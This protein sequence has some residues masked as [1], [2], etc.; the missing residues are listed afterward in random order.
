MK[1]KGQ[2]EKADG[3]TAVTTD[4]I[5]AAE[6]ASS[7]TNIFKRAKGKAQYDQN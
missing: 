3:H 1:G 6:Q 5:A 4:G 7:A 2:T